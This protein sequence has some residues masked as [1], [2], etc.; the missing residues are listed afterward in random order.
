MA[1]NATCINID[2]RYA[3][4]N[5]CTPKMLLVFKRTLNIHIKQQVYSKVGR[6]TQNRVD[7]LKRRLVYLKDGSC[8]HKMVLVCSKDGR[9][10]KICL[11]KKKYGKSTHKDSFCK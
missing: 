11:C 5:I 4:K 2:G 7:V 10:T 8:A 9:H 1:A 6:C 3:K